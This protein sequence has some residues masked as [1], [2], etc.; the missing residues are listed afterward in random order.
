MKIKISENIFE[1][2]STKRENPLGGDSTSSVVYIGDKI[3]K[4]IPIE[5]D[6][7]Y[8]ELLQYKVM[9]ENQNIFPKTSVKKLREGDSYVIIQEKLD[10]KQAEKIFNKINS[11]FLNH[12]LRNLL[13]DIALFGLTNDNEKIVTE[14][15]KKITEDYKN[16]FNRFVKISEELYSILK[17]YQD[18][19]APDL[20]SGNY[21]FDSKGVLKVFDFA[22]PS[23]KKQIQS[24]EVIPKTPL[25]SNINKSYAL[26]LPQTALLL[27]EKFGLGFYNNSQPGRSIDK[28][29]EVMS[30]K[31]GM[32]ANQ[33]S[34][35]LIPSY[36]EITT[37]GKDFVDFLEKNLQYG[38]KYSVPDYRFI[39]NYDYISKLFNNYFPSKNGINKKSFLRFIENFLDMGI[40][41][42]SNPKKFNK[43]MFGDI[44]PSIQM[45]YLDEFFEGLQEFGLPI[46][47]VEAK[48]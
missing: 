8:F 47:M 12:G 48:K 33:G 6:Y 23:Y 20:H 41:N 25:E 40:K 13:E 45:S 16:Y 11:S 38:Q 27:D 36:F 26:T 4:K 29:L 44:S 32:Y 3:V 37:K 10:T 9:S 5:G 18:L 14:T 19:T 30:D 24:K 2:L 28:V 42:T 35:K 46:N 1:A 7:P 15:E 31:D 22:S 17:K 21:G 34:I 39:K 43:D